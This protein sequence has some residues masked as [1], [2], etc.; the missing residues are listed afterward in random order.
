MPAI[1]QIELHPYFQ[2][3]SCGTSTPCTA[4]SPR[5]G[6]RW[7]PASGVLDDPVIGAIAE[8]HGATPAQVVLRWHLQLGTS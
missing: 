4:S 7:R 3:A 5:P 6:A 1:N 8:R 2:Q